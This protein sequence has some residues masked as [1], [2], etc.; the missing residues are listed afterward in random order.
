MPVSYTH[1][2]VYKRQAVSAMI[3]TMI[4]GGLILRYDIYQVLGFGML[5][6]GIAID[7]YKR[8]GLRRE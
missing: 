1:L 3:Y 4:P 2:D 5:I 7:V 6:G 8:Q